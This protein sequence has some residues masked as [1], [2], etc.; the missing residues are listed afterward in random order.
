[1]GEQRREVASNLYKKARRTIQPSK[2]ISTAKLLG[3][4]Y[5]ALWMNHSPSGPAML[6]LFYI[7]YAYI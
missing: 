1:V 4:D 5:Q 7:S 6:Y 2:L 3:V